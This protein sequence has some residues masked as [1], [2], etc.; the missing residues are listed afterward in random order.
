MAGYSLRRRYSNSS[1]SETSTVRAASSGG[2]LGSDQVAGRGA[3]NYYAPGNTRGGWRGR[4]TFAGGR[5]RGGGRYGTYFPR[6]V[7]PPPQRPNDQQLLE[8]R[9]AAREARASEQHRCVEDN[10][11]DARRKAAAKI[12][13]ETREH[14]SRGARKVAAAPMV[15]AEA[16]PAGP[17]ANTNVARVIV[18]GRFIRADDDR[19]R[20]Y[21]DEEVKEVLA[22]LK[23]Q[24]ES[25]AYWEK[26]QAPGPVGSEYAAMMEKAKKIWEAK[27]RWRARYP[28]HRYDFSYLCMENPAVPRFN[29]RGVWGGLY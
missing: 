1:A 15:G 25:G 26:L 3:H 12:L 13:L 10:D 18:G 23:V 16:G 4:G 28:P 24:K 5:G 11:I 21:D 14:R 22:K 27:L 6:P 7:S 9:D 29:I 19:Q 20:Y 8:R 2:A 17:E